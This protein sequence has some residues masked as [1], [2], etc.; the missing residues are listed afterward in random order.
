MASNTESGIESEVVECRYC[1]EEVDYLEE[2]HFKYPSDK[3]A[4]PQCVADDCFGK[5]EPVA[6][7]E[8]VFRLERVT[9]K[10]FV[11]QGQKESLVDS[12]WQ[13]DCPVCYQTHES[14]E[15]GEDARMELFGGVLDCCGA[16]WMPPAGWVEDCDI[17]GDDHRGEFNCTPLSW[18]KPFPGIDNDYVCAE[19][20]TE[21]HGSDLDGPNGACP[22]CGSEALKEASA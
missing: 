20:D 22:E 16:E 6:T 10:K 9:I 15:S 2:G 14:E 12:Y 1:G 7:T 5:R 13:A 19:C 4:H 17:C 8:G 3:F 18:R 11:G 21:N